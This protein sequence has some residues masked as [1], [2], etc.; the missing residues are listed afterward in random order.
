[1]CTLVPINFAGEVELQQLP[2]VG[3][4]IAR[5]IVQYREENF[6]ITPANIEYI[7]RLRLSEMLVRSID[8]T[9]DPYCRRASTQP[10]QGPTREPVAPTQ[11]DNRIGSSGRQ[12]P[13]EP[14]PGSA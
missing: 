10:D 14:P 5:N 4:R 9:T 13:T 12:K 3:S 2:E 11:Q 1:M 7:H 8:F 6:P